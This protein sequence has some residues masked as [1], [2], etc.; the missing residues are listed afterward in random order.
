MT[1]CLINGCSY[2]V[3]WQLESLPF[4]TV[5]I[6]HYG[7][8]NP[9]T[10]RTTLN[11]ILIEPEAPTLALISLT[12][13]HRYEYWSDQGPIDI[14]GSGNTSTDPELNQALDTLTNRRDYAQILDDFVNTAVLLQHL[15]R[16]RRIPYVIFNQCNRFQRPDLEAKT[17]AKLE[18]L[19]RDRR[20][21]NL[22]EFIANDYLYRQNIP[23]MDTELEPTYRHYDTA[24]FRPLE[25]YLLNY[26]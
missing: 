23:S 8:S 3:G 18:Q 10:L 26:L 9:R 13:A 21:I 22:T 5:N 6:A 4:K 20:V 7:G 11:Q 17:L 12:F 15:F 1:Y 2:V 16:A 25:L 14:W 24:K 19:D